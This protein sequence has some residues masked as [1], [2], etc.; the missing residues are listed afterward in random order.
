MSATVSRQLKAF[1]VRCNGYM[2]V[3]GTSC[4]LYPSCAFSFH[5]FHTKPKPKDATFEAAST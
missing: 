5:L 4:R 1:H 2:R 3:R